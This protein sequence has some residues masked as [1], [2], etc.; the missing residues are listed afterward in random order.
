MEK[1]GAGLVPARNGIKFRAGTRPARKIVFVGLGSN[2]GDRR[3][4]ILRSIDM[5]ERTRGIR[6]LDRSTIIET[7]PVGPVQDQPKFINAAVAIETTLS[8]IELLDQLHTI[9]ETL[10]RVRRERWGPRLIDLDILLYGD[11]TIN[12]PRLVVPHPEIRNRPFVQTALR[13]LGAAAL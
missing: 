7:E 11:E 1:V 2:L 9:E 4:N 12:H 10:G 8:P 3:N 13:E 5:L 6:V